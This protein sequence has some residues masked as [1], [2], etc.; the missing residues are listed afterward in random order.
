MKFKTLSI[1]ALLGLFSVGS[2]FAGDYRNQKSHKVKTN[3]TVKVI[4]RP[5]T[6]TRVVSTKNGIKRVTTENNNHASDQRIVKKSVVT[7]K[8]SRSSSGDRVGLFVGG[9]VLGSFF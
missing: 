4:E 3:K 2:A 1:V 7:N 8:S 6:T 9:L 5:H